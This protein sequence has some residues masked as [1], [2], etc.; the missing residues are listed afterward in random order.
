MHTETPASS[1]FV[2]LRDRVAEHGD[3]PAVSYADRTWTYAQLDARASRL[4]HWLDGRMAHAGCAGA[5]VPMCLGRGLDAIAAMLAA[6]KL[7][8]AY[9]PVDPRMPAGRIRALLEETGAGVCL[10]DRSTRALL[11]EAGARVELGPLYTVLDVVVARQVHL[12]FRARLLDLDLDPG[13]ETQECALFAVDA[14]PWDE[15]SFRSVRG[16]LR[17]YVADLATGTFGV[18]QRA[19]SDD[20][21]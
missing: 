19:V 2:D 12:Y 7:G 18:H 20:D 16:T 9:V 6:L 13:P 11:E 5:L 21:L 15:L 4:A 1:P 14:L 3:A 8:A 10:V 17:H